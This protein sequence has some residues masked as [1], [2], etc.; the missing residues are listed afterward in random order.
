MD[1]RASVYMDA[2]YKK[3]SVN[4]F[5]KQNTFIYGEIGDRLQSSKDSDVYKMSAHTIKNLMTLQS[6]SLEMLKGF[7]KQKVTKDGFDYSNTSE[8]IHFISTK[9]SKDL[10]FLDSKILVIDPTKAITQEIN[11][12]STYDLSLFNIKFI[13]DKLFLINPND[14]TKNLVYKYDTTTGTL[15]TDNYFS[16]LSFYLKNRDKVSIDVYLI[17]E[18]YDPTDSTYVRKLLYPAKQSTVDSDS[19]DFVF[20]AD[21]TLSLKGIEDKKIKRIYYPY[22]AGFDALNTPQTGITKGDIWI[23]IY[24]I[25]EIEG[26]TLVAGNYYFNL[27]GTT[28]ATDSTGTYYTKV[29]FGTTPPTLPFTK[30]IDY[31]T[32]IKL[33]S[34]ATDVAEF[35]GRTYISYGKFIYASKVGDYYDFRN[36]I[37]DSDPFRFEL[38]AQEGDIPNIK[39]LAVGRGMFATT[40]AGIFIIGYNE[41][42]K[43]STINVRFVSDEIAINQNVIIDDCFYFLTVDQELRAIQNKAQQKGYLDF[44]SVEV[45]EYSTNIYKKLMKITLNKNTYMLG[46]TTKDEIRIFKELWYIDLGTFS[47]TTIDCFTTGFYAHNKK[48]YQNIDGLLYFTVQNKNNYLEAYLR[49]NTPQYI[50]PDVGDILSDS[51]VKVTRIV[52]KALNE[53]K[54]AIK[55]MAING[56]N[57]DFTNSESTAKT[58]FVNSMKIKTTGDDKLELVITTNENEKDLEI[59]A[60]EI[61]YVV[62]N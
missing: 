23:S 14:S 28:K 48:Y 36:W 19:G 41:F 10:L 53:D 55:S 58:F 35:Q 49:L 34:G 61:A 62:N 1:K 6:G 33:D 56:T 26:S 51:R 42:V 13:D 31:G 59:E 40:T 43:P 15:I 16:N 5:Y 50:S 54:E 18:T 22:Q 37:N 52:A 46:I 12:G 21:F 4:N 39:N 38:S 9:F 44:G 30:K 20:N 45:D 2:S 24:P 60:T 25:N 3:E 11:L 8:I 27:D 47:R 29:T 32:V 57:L 17:K 7:D